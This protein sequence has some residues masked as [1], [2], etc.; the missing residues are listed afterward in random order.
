M[1]KSKIQKLICIVLALM[2][3]IPFTV[4]SASAEGE[5][6]QHP[7]P[8]YCESCVQ[9]FNSKFRKYY[10]YDLFSSSNT[11]LNGYYLFIQKYISSDVIDHF[12]F[13]FAKNPHSVTYHTGSEEG[14]WVSSKTSFSY[15][16]NVPRDSSVTVD[17][18][19]I[20]IPDKYFSRSGFFEYNP[21]NNSFTSGTSDSPSICYYIS[22]NMDAYLV[23]HPN[24]VSVFPCYFEHPVH[25]S[26]YELFSKSFNGPFFEMLSSIHSFFAD[27]A[28]VLLI[29]SFSF[30]G[31][32]VGLVKRLSR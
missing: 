19:S 30:I 17:L 1:I 12:T 9:Q 13:V 27:N 11:A 6:S 24:A 23:E 25:I 4:V 16:V 5:T 14:P 18:S 21:S 28:L 22:T 7:Y 15:S 26:D 2:T 20:V 31:A 8:C 29:F 32:I 3:L 10:G